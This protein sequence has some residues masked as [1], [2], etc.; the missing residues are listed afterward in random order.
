MENKK[1]MSWAIVILVLI[2][3]WPVGV[4]LL[5]RKVTGD[6]ASAL[7]NSKILRNVGF[8]FLGFAIIYIFMVI[9][10]QMDDAWTAA[11]F[12]GIGGGVL[13]Y[14]AKRLKM[15]GEKFKKY[16]NIVINNNQTSIDNIAAAIPISYDKAAKD[17]Q[18]M[19]NKG[20]FSNAYIDVSNRE[21][22]LPSHMKQQSERNGS[23]KNNNEQAKVKSVICKNCGGNNEVIE[24]QA[25]ECEYC[26]SPIN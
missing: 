1:S 25:C 7:K 14:A 10:G 2:F 16:I 22:I 8:V 20:Y 15:T 9:S 3:F 26:G 21:I 5:Y 12:F 24:G 17:L 6:R 13:V 11:A 18:E 23:L 4:Y 19:I